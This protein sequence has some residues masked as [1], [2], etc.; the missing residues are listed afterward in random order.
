LHEIPPVLV[1]PGAYFTIAREAEPGFH[2]DLVLPL[3]RRNRADSSAVLG[4]GHDIDRVSYDGPKDFAI[5][6]SA[7]W[8][9]RSRPSTA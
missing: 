9:P 8:P 4:Q 1:E 6:P 2:E 5:K 3:S 7:T